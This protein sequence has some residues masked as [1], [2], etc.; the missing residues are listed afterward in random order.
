LMSIFLSG[1][2]YLIT[3]IIIMITR[4]IEAD[5]LSLRV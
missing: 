4:R 3:I 2:T 1:T 5:L